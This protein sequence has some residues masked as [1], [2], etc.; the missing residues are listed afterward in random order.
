MASF[1]RKC[2]RC[3]GDGQIPLSTPK[4]HSQPDG[5][6]FVTDDLIDCPDCNG[7]GTVLTPISVPV[8]VSPDNR[9][10]KPFIMTVHPNGVLEFREKGHRTTIQTTV[11]AA[12]NRAMQMP[13]YRLNPKTKRRKVSRGLL[14]L[15]KGK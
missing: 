1:T 11:Q 5:S 2:R 3:G 4:A 13:E 9:A 6:N 12:F 8:K 10:A 7:D 14:S 15:T